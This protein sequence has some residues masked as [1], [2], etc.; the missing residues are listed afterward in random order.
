MPSKRKPT[1][2]LD[3]P[4]ELRHMI[5][6]PC[7]LR[8]YTI[9]L[10]PRPIDNTS[11]SNTR[12]DRKKS[13]LPVSK[14][15]SEE[16]MGIKYGENVF[17]LLLPGC[18]N[19]YYL[20]NGRQVSFHDTISPNNVGHIRKLSLILDPFNLAHLTE[21]E[22]GFCTQVFPQ[23]NRLVV[24]TYRSRERSEH[25]WPKVNSRE[26]YVAAWEGWCGPILEFVSQQVRDTLVVEVDTDNRTE[27]IR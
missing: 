13:L 2:F 20:Q 12:N 18:D 8:G 19:Y 24:V 26:S 1:G 27:T 7:L 25:P 22:T 23:L 16:S 10:I 14:Q 4:V 17:R 6:R 5:Y 3:L 21:R 15:I 9:D 11:Q